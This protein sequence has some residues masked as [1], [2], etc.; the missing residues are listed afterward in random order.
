MISECKKINIP[1]ETQVPDND[2]EEDDFF[3]VLN[4]QSEA[5][6]HDIQTEVY[7]YFQNKN[8]NQNKNKKSVLLDV[9]N[10]HIKEVFLK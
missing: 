1:E 3:S 10:M 7:E 2:S 5:P 9:K 4:I 6:N 8:K